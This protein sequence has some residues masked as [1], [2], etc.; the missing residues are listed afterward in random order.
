MT[1][2]LLSKLLGWA[3]EA[4]FL[5]LVEQCEGVGS[6]RQ[7]R[8]GFEKQIS[9]YI[10]WCESVFFSTHQTEGRELLESGGPRQRRSCF[11][12]TFKR[13]SIDRNVDISAVKDSVSLEEWRCAENSDPN[14]ETLKPGPGLLLSLE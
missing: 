12:R 2:E 5:C 9:S 13:Q 10:W 1:P 7:R 6:F 3:T 4:S 8:S 14:D 11:K